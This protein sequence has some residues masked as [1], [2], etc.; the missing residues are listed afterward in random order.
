[1]IS[2]TLNKE[3]F[4]PLLFIYSPLGSFTDS[5]KSVR[6]RKSSEKTVFPISQPNIHNFVTSRNSNTRI[7]I[8]VKFNMTG[9]IHNISNVSSKV[10]LSN[11]NR[12]LHKSVLKPRSIGTC[13]PTQKAANIPHVKLN[14]RKPSNKQSF[15]LY[16]N[17]I[18]TPGLN[19]YK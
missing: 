9:P 13:N 10:H 8:P 18:V 16:P 5:T 4:P 6:V 3:E 14:I 19:T 11:A 17:V 1:M 2:F 7:K 15:K 12:V